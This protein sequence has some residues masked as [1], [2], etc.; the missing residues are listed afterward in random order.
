MD[1]NSNILFAGSDEP[2]SARTLIL[3]LVDTGAPPAL[4]VR[5]LVR[6]GAAFGIEPTGIRTALTRL[7]AEGRIR[8]V[9]RG[10]YA[11]GASGALLQQ[12]ILGWRTVLER[13]RDWR[14]DWLFAI[15]GPQER[16]DRTIWRRT[17]RALGLEG[18]AEAEI[19]VWARPDNLA[20]G[21]AGMRQRLAEL[22]AAPSLLVV[23]ARALDPER[24]ARFQTLWNGHAL[25]D[26]HA[27]LA[28]LLDR[29]AAGI[30]QADLPGAAVE[31][32]LLG[33]QAIRNIMRDPLLPDALCPT[34]AL[35]RLIA[36]MTDY[37]RLGKRIW[38][39]FLSD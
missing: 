34:R 23:Q 18:F 38:H 3:D 12:R 9:E 31:T 19:N 13:R 24:A 6:A 1:V 14:G 15:A 32:L 37:D 26:G 22:E 17:V 10:R 11:I 4:S 20:D 16:A 30:D 21:A 28:D 2:L 33:R 39:A 7:K 5:E 35:S 8:Q 27:R 25:Q 29:S 36:S